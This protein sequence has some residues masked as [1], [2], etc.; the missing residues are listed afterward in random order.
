[1]K[2]EV[3][4]IAG[5]NIKEVVLDPE[6]GKTFVFFKDGSVIAIKEQKVVLKVGDGVAEFDNIA[7]FRDFIAQ[8]TNV[9]TLRRGL[10]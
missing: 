9:R 10:N 1:M 4:V 5:A 7:K 6:T 8:H 2:D 3:A